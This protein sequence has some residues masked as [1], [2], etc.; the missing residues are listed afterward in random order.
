[1]QEKKAQK[2]SN[3]LK[4]HRE[5]WKEKSKKIAQGGTQS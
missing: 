5:V 1:M 3:E 4:M 2:T